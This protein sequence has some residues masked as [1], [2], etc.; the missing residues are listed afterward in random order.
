MTV[1]ELGASSTDSVT[2]DAAVTSSTVVSRASTFTCPLTV[3]VTSSSKLRNP[4]CEMRRRCLPIGS[5]STVGVK[6]TGLASTVISASRTSAFTTTLPV[7]A[8]I[9]ARSVTT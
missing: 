5:A 2:R 6:P 8:S 3:T 9:F 7:C 4:I 1:T